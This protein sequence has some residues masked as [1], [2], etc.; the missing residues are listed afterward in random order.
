MSETLQKL[1]DCEINFEISCFYDGGFDAALGD[2][3]NGW[4]DHV[5]GE[6]LNECIGNLVVAAIKRY[7]ECEKHLRGF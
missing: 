4:T 7:P 1:Y 5:G 6:T 2:S 3:R